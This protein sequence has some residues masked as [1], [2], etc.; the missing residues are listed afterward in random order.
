[1]SAPR[2]RLVVRNH[3]PGRRAM[4]IIVV[5]VLVL[6]AFGAAFE[7]GRSRAGFDDAAARSERADLKDKIA[8]LE[9]QLRATRLKVAMYETDTAGQTH[10]KT[11]LS[12]TI[13]ELQA[14][15]ARLTSDV[16][17]YRGVVEERTTGDVLKIQQFQVM[18]GKT[19][20]EF[21]LRLVIGRPLRSEDSISGKA[22]MTIE[23]TDADGK[24]ASLDL[25]KIG[26]V[27]DGELAFS[28]RYVT[29]L[30]Q[31]VELP[32]GFAP[33]RTNVELTPSRKGANPVRETFVWNVEN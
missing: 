29:T 19:G 24:Q 13:G 18:P 23:G 14:E 8:S 28:M 11:E 3:A 16:A 2:P 25:Q 9:E 20:R 31:T 15:V 22:R 1:M 27:T 33:A 30:E 32:E 7:W 4:W 26:G 17:F 21:V 12:K 6:G 10:E 5:T